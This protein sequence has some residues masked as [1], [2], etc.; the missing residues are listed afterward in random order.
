[1]KNLCSIVAVIL[2]SVVWS[3]HAD[4]S[5]SLNAANTLA[6]KWMIVEQ[7]SADWYKLDSDITRKEIMKVV[8]KISWKEVIDA[9]SGKF[10][11]VTDDWGC[12]Y[13]EAALSESFIAENPDFRPNDSITKAESMKLILKARGI[14]K[15]HDTGD[16][17]D[18]YMLTAYD[19][20]IILSKYTNHNDEARRWWIFLSAISWDSWE[21]IAWPLENSESDNTID[22]SVE[23]DD[24]IE[25]LSDE[26]NTD[27][28]NELT[29]L[30]ASEDS[31]IDDDPT[32]DFLDQL[33]AWLED[34]N[35]NPVT[36]YKPYDDSLIGVN[37]NMV[38]FFHASWCSS[39]VATDKSL[40]NE[41]FISKDILILKVNYDKSAE[42]KEKYW[43]TTQHTFV[44][45][46]ESW[47]LVKKWLWSTNL[48]DIQNQIQ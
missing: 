46:D 21:M 11:D 17:R 32:T 37:A 23:E 43:V 39:C 48:E 5:L 8:M 22:A 10:W 12:K 1:M 42:L 14:E 27:Q 41:D 24:S 28:P 20:K 36:G 35:V 45:V 34:E 19:K 30:A 26:S 3:V 29:E 25:E 44:Q 33:L 4:E 18:D 7:D 47:E 6:S 13:I 2:L 16:W 9:C 31:D 38:L 40:N 15:T